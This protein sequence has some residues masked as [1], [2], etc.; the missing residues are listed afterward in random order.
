LPEPVASSSPLPCRP[1]ISGVVSSDLFGPVSG[2][3]ELFPLVLNIQ[4]ACRRIEISQAR[5]HV[6]A[7]VES[8]VSTENRVD[9]EV[10]E[11]A[12]GNAA[13]VVTIRLF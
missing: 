4:Q 1:P 2:D 12:S 7:L 8:E 6:D 5:V 10:G 13:P 3:V 11:A 9:H